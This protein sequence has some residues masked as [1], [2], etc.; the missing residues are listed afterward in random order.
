M[1]RKTHRFVSLTSPTPR[2]RLLGHNSVLM[3]VSPI[4]KGLRVT[5]PPA[6]RLQWFALHC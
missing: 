1:V 3:S 4:R 6:E 5:L 2:T